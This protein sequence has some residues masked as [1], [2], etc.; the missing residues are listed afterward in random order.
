MEVLWVTFCEL[1]MQQISIELNTGGRLWCGMCAYS[2]IQSNIKHSHLFQ[3]SCY[4][5][6]F[7]SCAVV[8]VHRCKSS[9]VDLDTKMLTVFVSPPPTLSYKSMTVHQ[10]MCHLGRL[11]HIWAAVHIVIF[12]FFKCLQIGVVGRARGAKVS[13][14]AGETPTNPDGQWPPYWL[15]QTCTLRE[16][17]LTWQSG[18]KFT[19]RC[20]DCV[21]TDQ[22][23]KLGQ[24]CLIIHPMAWSVWFLWIAAHVS[25]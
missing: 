9:G 1:S 20:P 8:W 19:C 4:W 12:N 23:G 6:W 22:E 24:H 18:H 16:H 5:R 15:W 3:P 13:R 21:T 11:M 10:H 14:P 7:S 2:V 25:N 17:S